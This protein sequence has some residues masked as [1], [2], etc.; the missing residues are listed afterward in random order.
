M[1]DGIIKPLGKNWPKAFKKRHVELKLRKVKAV[2]WNRY[3]SH[4]YDKVTHWFEVIGK[5]L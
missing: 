3:N 1:R 4:I 2:D 5:E